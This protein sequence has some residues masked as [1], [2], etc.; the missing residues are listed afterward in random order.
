VVRANELRKVLSVIHEMGFVKTL[1]KSEEMPNG[2]PFFRMD[3]FGGIV[4]RQCYLDFCHVFK[5]GS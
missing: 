1:E 2:K 3:V 5:V 4:I